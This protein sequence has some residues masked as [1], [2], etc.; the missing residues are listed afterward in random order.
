M[1][2]FGGLHFKTAKEGVQW[3]DRQR[4]TLLDE[5]VDVVLSNLAALP[6]V[7]LVAGESRSRV[8]GYYHR[9]R[10]RMRYS[11]FRDRGLQI[12]SGPLEAAHRSVVQCRMKRSGQ[13]WSDEGAQA[14]LNL[15]AAFKSE[16][17]NLVTERLSQL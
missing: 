7:S 6:N 12:G 13:R 17:W 14:M 4:A 9:N 3:L 5:G 10:H 15:R 2:E 16:R 8:V 1:A 11:Q